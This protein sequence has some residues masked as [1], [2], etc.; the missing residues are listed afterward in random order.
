MTSVWFPI[1]KLCILDISPDRFIQLSFSVLLCSSFTGGVHRCSALCQRYGQKKQ[2]AAQNYWS[3]IPLRQS[4]AVKTLQESRNGLC[5]SPGCE[6]TS[7]FKSLPW[8]L[9]HTSD[10]VW[11]VLINCYHIIL[12]LAQHRIKSGTQT[13]L[14]CL[15]KT[16]RL[17]WG[18]PNGI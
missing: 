6:I 10:P 8:D 5:H 4:R 17:L 3:A 13:E 2:V 9:F 14:W 11:L 18:P 15:V 12:C 7:Q 16:A 1:P